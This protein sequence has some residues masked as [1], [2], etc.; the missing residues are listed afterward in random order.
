MSKPFLQEVDPLIRARYPMLYI[1][2]WEETRALQLLAQVASK[3]RK[4]V[5]E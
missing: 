5:F 4:A 1:V 3:Q 2:T